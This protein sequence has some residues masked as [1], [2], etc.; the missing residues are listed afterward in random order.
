[1]ASDA[2]ARRVL[3]LLNPSAGSR[4]GL[5]RVAALRE[6]LAQRN[7]VVDVLSDVEDLANRAAALRSSGDLRAVIAAGGDGTVALV[8]NRTREG[9]P[10]GVLPLGTENLL[11]K[12]LGITGD[13]AQL[14][15]TVYGGKTVRLDAGRAGNRLFLLMWSCGFDAD[16]VR[17]LHQERRGHIV[18]CSYAKPILESIC[19]YP[20]PRLRVYGA[21]AEGGPQPAPSARRDAPAA[22]RVPLWTGCWL[23]VMNLPCYAAGLGIVPDAVGDDGLLDMCAFRGGSVWSG[24]RYLAGV[25]LGCH[26]SWRDCTAFRVRRLRVESDDPVPYQIDGDPGGWLPVDVEV[27][28]GRLTLLV[29]EGPLG[30]G[31]SG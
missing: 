19:S 16:V 30:E 8:A 31:G 4:S 12:H 5:P 21:P 10:I 13:A 28:P 14:T 27:L 24:M 2:G 29:P 9:T 15:R 22:S 25:L 18:R 11:S 17:R 3:I 26:R 20:F 23:F 7:L 6:Q 1:M